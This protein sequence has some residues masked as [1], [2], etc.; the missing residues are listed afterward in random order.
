M[1]PIVLTFAVITCREL[2]GGEG[3][4]RRN[5]RERGGREESVPVCVP[6]CV[7]A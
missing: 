6:V 2:G 4:R 7:H 1:T 5:G 3:G